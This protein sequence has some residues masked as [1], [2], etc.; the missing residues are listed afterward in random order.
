MGSYELIIERLNQFVSKFYKKQLVKGLLLFLALGGLLF[1]ALLSLEYFLWMGS[2]GRLTLFLLMCIGGAYLFYRYIATPLFYLFRIKQGLSIKEASLLI[3][4]H[5]AQVNDKLYNLLDLAENKERSELL[6]A[7]IEQ[8]SKELD[9]VPFLMAIN[10]KDSLRYAK[11]ILA[12]LAIVGLLWLSGSISSFFGSYDR[13][14]NYDLAYEPPAPFAFQLLTEKLT[15]L[16]NEPL[17]LRVSTSGELRPQ[18]M[19][20]VIGGEQLMM[21]D[22]NGVFE[23]SI[24][25]PVAETRFYF[26]ANDFNSREYEMKSLSTPVLQDFTMA[27]EY[28]KYT[29]RT[30]EILKG[31]G[32]AVI[33]E[34]TLVI[35]SIKGKNIERINW[36]DNDTLVSFNE[37]QNGFSLSKRFFRNTEYSVATSN[38]NVR[39]YERLNYSFSV[40]RDAHPTIKADQFIDSL[41]VNVSYYSGQVADDYKV[42]QVRVVC[43][44]AEDKNNAQRLVLERPNSNVSQFY[45]T[46]SLIHI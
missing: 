27:L 44:P 38:E 42:S 10:V 6:M 37:D 33:P 45:Y 1:F 26:V 4:K 13:V 7:S 43:Y 2:S 17:Q 15:V 36:S 8:R 21:Q 22:N 41:A 32:N 25:A 34:G 14:V 28:P 29:G 20:V 40:V 3:G 23:Y 30:N 24:E 35:W 5:F 11:Y 9:A 18:N 12:P 39:D 16:D 46:L 31:T 19:Y